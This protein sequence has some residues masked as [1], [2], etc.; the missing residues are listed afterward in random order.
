MMIVARREHTMKGGGKRKGSE[1][2]KQLSGHLWTVKSLHT[3]VTF[4]STLT[5]L[6]TG[7]HW[8]G[9]DLQK[10]ASSSG[11]R[12]A[13][14]RCSTLALREGASVDVDLTI[15]H[16]DSSPLALDPWAV[17]KGPRGLGMD[18]QVDSERS[19][20]CFPR[21]ALQTSL[22]L[23]ESQSFYVSSQACLDQLVTEM[24]LVT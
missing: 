18:P 10:M 15:S 2:R 19:E 22:P 5:P 11:C 20:Q 21:P 7:L 6:L 14:E 1:G 24:L 13:C 23:S 4:V 12:R 9:P 8:T 17:D 3:L 16:S